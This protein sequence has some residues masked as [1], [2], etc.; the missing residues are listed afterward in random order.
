MGFGVND[1]GEFHNQE[2][3]NRVAIKDD[4][5][6]FGLVIIPGL[7]NTQGEVKCLSGEASYKHCNL[8]IHIGGD[9]LGNTSGDL[10]N[11]CTELF[12]VEE[13][14]LEITNRHIRSS[15]DDVW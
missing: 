3:W 7:V 11:S 6:L 1:V 15:R 8:I 4:S 14:G 12:P 9:H 13:I 2:I 10:I 5:Q